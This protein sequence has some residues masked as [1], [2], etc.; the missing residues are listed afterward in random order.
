MAGSV[1]LMIVNES[2]T[3]PAPCPLKQQLRHRI[4][5]LVPTIYLVGSMN[6][7]ND[8]RAFEGVLATE[9]A[10]KPLTPARFVPVMHTLIQ[11]WTQKPL[12]DVRSVTC[13]LP[14]AMSVRRSRC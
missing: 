14:K 12:A 8:V 2:E 9:V 5:S 4:A 1:D 10:M 3:F 7:K 11:K 6:R 13:S